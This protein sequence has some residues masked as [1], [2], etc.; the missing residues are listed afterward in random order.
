MSKL[1][2]VLTIILFGCGERLNLEQL[3]STP[4]KIISLT[5]AQEYSEKISMMDLISEFKFIELND[6]DKFFVSKIKK[7]EFDE[8]GMFILEEN[9]KLLV[10]F[11][12]SG[13]FL[14][15]IGSKGMGPGQ[16]KEATDFFIDEIRREIFIYDRADQALNIFDFQGNF[17][18]K[19]KIGLFAFH[20]SNL[21]ENRIAFYLDM[22]GKR[23][24]GYNILIYDLEKRKFINMRMPFPIDKDYISFQYSG[25]L[26]DEYYTY[27]LSSRIYKLNLEENMDKNII[28]VELENL[29]DEDEI[30]SH[31]KFLN[32]NFSNQ[33]NLLMDFSISDND[34]IFFSHHY[35]KGQNKFIGLALKNRDGQVF[36][37]KNLLL[38]PDAGLFEKLFF[39]PNIVPLYSKKLK[40]FVSYSN[41]E[42]PKSK[43]SFENTAIPE[44][45]RTL[46]SKTMERNYDQNP[47]LLVYSLKEKYE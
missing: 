13:N 34:E 40:K 38:G 46:V 11:D 12:S 44:K 47:I 28:K 17:I 23:D 14:F 5:D 7:I 37:Y 31:E 6:T 41:N 9:K 30:F 19:I 1:I 16:Y 22:D 35:Q 21:G 3:A 42:L 29:F 43:L 45:F 24:G 2:I 27:P 18:E 8:S 36:C 33:K 10:K 32:D 39:S 26:K 20:V 15:E 25:F 4:S